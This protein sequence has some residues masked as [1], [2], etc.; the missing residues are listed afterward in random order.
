MVWGLRHI[1][2]PWFMVHGPW[3]D[4]WIMIW[5]MLI[6]HH[7]SPK[8]IPYSFEHGTYAHQLRTM[9][10]THVC[11]LWYIYIHTMITCVY[12]C[13]VHF[14]LSLKL[15]MYVCNQ[16]HVYMVLAHFA[17]CQATSQ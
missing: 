17:Y 2:V 4:W 1:N 8:G 9:N 5:I 6:H 12:M 13:I 15:D 11:M 16:Y 14:N 10:N 3:W 7:P